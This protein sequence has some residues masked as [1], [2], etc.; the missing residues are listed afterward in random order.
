VTLLA[1]PLAAALKKLSRFGV[2]RLVTG[3]EAV[4]VEQTA[5]LAVV[6]HDG[7][8][9]TLRAGGAELWLFPEHW[10]VAFEVTE[11]A[12]PADPIS[13]RFFHAS[14]STPQARFATGG[15]PILEI[16]ADPSGGTADGPNL[17]STVAR[18]RAGGFHVRGEHNQKRPHP[19]PPGLTT[20]G[21]A[22]ALA[23]ARNSGDAALVRALSHQYGMPRVDALSMLGERW[24][25][26]LRRPALLDLLQRIS[27][28]GLAVT[29][30]AGNE[31]LS[32]VRDGVLGDV[33]GNGR[34][35]CLREPGLSIDVGTLSLDSVWAVRLR[36]GDDDLSSLE[37]FD[38]TGAPAL[39]VFGV[40][41]RWGSET[42]SQH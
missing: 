10:R 33:V 29:L 30:V 8:R 1:V 9:L 7:G 26:R 12:N 20:F 36:S 40:P 37:I 35:T 16:V 19:R 18:W 27:R 13:F 21:A 23:R 6:D 2:L 11:P 41:H 42:L 15:E 28:R 17:R 25:R 32:F 38:R 22:T 34:D 39:L 3:S 5:E 31:G 14:R 4:R 24:A